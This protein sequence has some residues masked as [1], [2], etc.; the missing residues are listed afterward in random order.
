M[1]SIWLRMITISWYLIILSCGHMI[2]ISTVYL[3]I[4]HVI[5]TM[6]R[7]TFGWNIKYQ[8]EFC[9]L[10]CYFQSLVQFST[11]LTTSKGFF[12]CFIIFLSQTV[13]HDWRIM[14]RIKEKKW[15]DYLFLFSFWKRSQLFGS[16]VT[17]ND[18]MYILLSNIIQIIN[19]VPVSSK[20]CRLCR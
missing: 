10:F 1:A 7:T 2:V 5:M 8:G 12:Q 9:H 16:A 13:A 15:E 18:V 6:I 4:H 14:K 11:V 17:T 20:Y 3:A 19:I